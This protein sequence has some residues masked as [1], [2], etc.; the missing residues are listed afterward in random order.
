MKIDLHCHTLKT[1]KGDNKGRNVTPEMFK[2]KIELADVKVVA[3]TNHNCFD[4]FQYSVLRDKVKDICQVWPGIE[5]DVQSTDSKN[6]FH[7]IIVSNPD[8]VE[9]FN[10]HVKHLFD[11]KDID[12]CIYTLEEI[13]GE[14]KDSDS[15]YVPHFHN[16]IPA[17][18]EDDRSKLISLVG[19]K[20]R[21]FIEPRDHRT[22]GVLANNNFNVMIGSDVKDWT[23]YEDCTFAELRL[24]IGSFSEFLLLSKRDS[25][26][27]K[28]LLGNK[29]PLTM[30]G[31]PHPS[32]NIKLSIYPDVNIIFGQKG[33]GKTEILKSLYE[34]MLK[35]GKNC[36]KYFASERSED[37]SS[38][39]SIKGIDADLEKVQV[40]SCEKEFESIKSWTDC[41]PTA[42][43]GYVS[44]IDT[45][46]NSNNKSRMKI[47]EAVHEVFSKDK[48]YD[49]HKKDKKNISEAIDKIESIALEHYIPFEDTVHLLKLLS[50]LQE[51]INEKRKLDVIE[52]E[53]IR[54]T[55]KSIDLI[56]TLADRNSDT[57]SRP[58]STGLISFAECRL[59]LYKSV[60]KILDS[61]SKPE[62]NERSLIGTLEDKGNIY[63]NNK[64]RMYC[65]E[66]KTDEFPDYSIRKLKQIQE[67]LKTIADNVF[68]ENIALEIDKLNELCNSNNVL[69][70]KPFLGV[71]KQVITEDGAVYSPSNGEKGILLLQ[72][73]LKED[74]D[75]YFLDEP[76]LGMGNSYIDTD[77]RPLISNLGKQ[78]KFVVVATHNAN[79]AVRTLPYLSIFRVHENGEYKT[80]VGNPFDDKLI[81][82]S[83][84][85]DVRSWTEESLHSLEGSKEAFYERRDIY[86][87]KD[88]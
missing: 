25:S 46:G 18:S 29:T 10:N 83:N 23:K 17:I 58:S 27:V 35:S 12:N 78:R 8:D 70:L 30:T 43:S 13:C 73:A 3:I 42:F 24:P 60:K 33:T 66:S 63:I 39:L 50:H 76:E 38:F 67:L 65:N 11:G 53:A 40:D 57:V 75:A 28:T 47:T 61:M 6:R 14:F 36:K 87:S 81:N 62:Y 48:F 41:N 15:I 34:E 54:L 51:M 79:I 69:S 64:Y 16:K 44:W 56:K 52:E 71:S 20:A 84:D 21:V 37:F 7:L 82:V 32:V 49:I 9:V 19:D 31:K 72:Q 5:I 45:R 26:V 74:A 86:E 4:I 1:K 80:Y 22:L 77:I 59:R 68:T 88:N 85:T 55:N 2:T